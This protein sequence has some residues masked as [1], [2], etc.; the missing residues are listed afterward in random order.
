MRLTLLLLTLALCTAFAAAAPAAP[1]VKP[2]G[3]ASEK[4]DKM[5]AGMRDGTYR[6]LGTRGFGFP[7]VG[8]EDVPALLA[9]AEE[10]GPLRTFPT[11]PLSSFARFGC[12]EG[13]AALWLVEGV[14]KGGKFPSLNAAIAGSED[15]EGA[16][17]EELKTAARA[18]RDWWARA[19][20]KPEA[21]KDLD[22]LAD[23]PVK[24]R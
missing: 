16:T 11:N 6:D 5:F 19:K 20:G 4:V 12:R 21:A 7:D 17:P 2:K 13:L 1:A 18:Y 3:P 23:S 24:W 10:E 14:R 22:P 8:W 15:R 9:R